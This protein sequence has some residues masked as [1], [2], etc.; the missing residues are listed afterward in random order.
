VANAYSEAYHLFSFSH[1]NPGYYI[2]LYDSSLQRIWIV[3][4]HGQWLNVWIL[5]YD[6]TAMRVSY[7]KEFTFDGD[8]RYFD[9]EFGMYVNSIKFS[10]DNRLYFF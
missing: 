8:Y 4:F 5:Q 2:S 6:P 9:G 1:S 10:T 7:Y 3:P